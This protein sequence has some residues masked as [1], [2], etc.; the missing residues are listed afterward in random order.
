MAIEQQ[1]LSSVLTS[2][3]CRTN[4][5][6]KNITEYMLPNIKEAFYLHIESNKPH[7]I[8]RPIFEV[9]AE[10]LASI[11]GVRKRE[12]YFHNGEMT[13]FPKRI[14]KGINEI[15]YGISFK[16]DDKKS[17]KLFIKKLINIING[18]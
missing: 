14:Y 15:H 1:E 17:V 4:F 6:I 3:E 9:F 2:L 8:I 11:E 7:L 10:D 18:G 5:T 12:A 13:R 16:F